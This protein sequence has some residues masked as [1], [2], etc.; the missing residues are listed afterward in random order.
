MTFWHHTCEVPWGRAKKAD[1]H[2]QTHTNT[3]TNTHTQ[4]HKHTTYTNKTERMYTW[5]HEHGLVCTHAHTHI[6]AH[7]RTHTD[8]NT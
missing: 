8:T 7:T 1:G 3:H 6:R 5:T 4:R 2:T